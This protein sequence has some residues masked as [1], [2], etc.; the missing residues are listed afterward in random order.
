M[1]LGNE[2]TEL[3]VEPFIP[4]P[5]I[6]LIVLPLPQGDGPPVVSAEGPIEVHLDTDMSHFVV[7]IDGNR[8][9]EDD[10][11]R[12]ATGAIIGVRPIPGPLSGARTHVVTV[13]ALMADGTLVADSRVVR[14][15]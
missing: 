1:R 9:T 4:G 5:A 13:G 11:I 10:L 14:V 12:D 3:T 15:A 6:G 2:L 8:A 7:A